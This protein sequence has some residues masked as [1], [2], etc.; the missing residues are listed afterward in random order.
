VGAKINLV[1]ELGPD[2]R[3]YGRQLGHGNNSLVRRIAARGLARLVERGE[4]AAETARASLL[5]YLEDFDLS[6]AL[7]VAVALASMDPVGEARPLR[8]RLVKLLDNPVERLAF[9][10]ATRVF[11]TIADDHLVETLKEAAEA[12]ARGTPGGPRLEPSAWILAELA[13]AGDGSV[14]RTLVCLL[15]D[16]KVSNR[17]AAAWGLGRSGRPEAFEPLKALLLSGNRVLVD[18]ALRGMAVADGSENADRMVDALRLDGRHDVRDR[19]KKLPSRIR[20]RPPA[21]PR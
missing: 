7:E 18:K 16:P 15:S 19:L 3:S 4:M 8:D 20:S 10:E 13:A 1:E 2:P 6:V 17:A 9:T 5:P 21:R 14:V 11:L 12:A